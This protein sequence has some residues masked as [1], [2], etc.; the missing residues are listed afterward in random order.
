MKPEESSNYQK[1]EREKEVVPLPYNIAAKLGLYEQN[2]H[3]QKAVHFQI[4][5]PSTIS[6]TKFATICDCTYMKFKYSTLQDG[7]AWTP[8]EGEGY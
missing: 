1:H 7:V 3:F 8:R 2:A 6:K 5:K 4:N